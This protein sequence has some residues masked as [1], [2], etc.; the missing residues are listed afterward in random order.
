MTGRVTPA[1]ANTAETF[2]QRRQRTLDAPCHGGTCRYSQV[3][4]MTHEEAVFALMEAEDE[5]CY[6]RSKAAGTWPS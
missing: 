3:M 2:H 5:L 1:V 6:L 4:R